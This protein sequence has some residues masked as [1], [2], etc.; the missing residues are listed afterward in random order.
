MSSTNPVA[1]LSPLSLALV[2]VRGV[3]LSLGLTGNTKIADGL[4]ALADA[5]EAGR[6]VD[7]HMAAVAEK[8]KARASTPE[9]W[10]EVVTAIEAD[11][12][13]LMAP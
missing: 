12:A 11:N 13:R 4:Y 7:A 1:G 3:A 10:A 6:N 8:L 9:D 5:A 2:A